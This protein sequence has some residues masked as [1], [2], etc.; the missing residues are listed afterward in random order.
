[1]SLFQDRYE[2]KKKVE[3]PLP[4]ST[5]NLRRDPLISSASSSSDFYSTISS[6]DKAHTAVA[7]IDETGLMT[8][9][10]QEI[11][12]DTDNDDDDDED[13]HQATPHRTKIPS[14]DS[15]SSF[16]RETNLRL[17]DGGSFEHPFRFRPWENGAGLSAENRD[18]C[19][20]I[21]PNRGF[22]SSK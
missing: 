19:A 20:I 13:H 12:E 6:G 21:R 7:A 2:T 16:P 14:F 10:R 4:P 15:E 5:T 3:G 18:P 8:T 22:L 1:M 11:W 9:Q 17:A